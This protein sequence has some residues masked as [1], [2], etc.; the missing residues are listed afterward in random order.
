MKRAKKVNGKVVGCKRLTDN[1]TLPT[2]S[3]ELKKKVEDGV[4]AGR[5][6][7]KN[8][9]YATAISCESKCAEAHLID[10]HG[11][12]GEDYITVMLVHKIREVIKF[13]S[14]REMLVQF[15]Q[16]IETVRNKIFVI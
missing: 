16:D 1:P 12:L 2:A 15:E 7:V 5:F 9:R 11:E 10:F 8:R 14:N 3:I 6:Y 4:Y 13:K